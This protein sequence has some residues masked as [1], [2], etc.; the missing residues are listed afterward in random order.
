[1]ERKRQ[2]F[3]LIELL[4]VIAI[5]AVLI[6]LLLPAVQKVRSSAASTQS[7]NNL[8]Q[9]GVAV[10]N[11]HD[12]YK[13]TPP[14]FGTYGG[15]NSPMGSLFYHLLPFLEQ[16]NLYQMG[17][18][19]ARSQPLKVLQ[20]PLDATYGTGLFTL[21]AAMP[22]WYAP[23]PATDN[24]IPPWAGPST[25]WG[26]SSYGAN[27][28]FFGDN[29]ITLLAVTDGTSHT[30]M[31]AEKYAVPTRPVGN[32][33]SGATLWG[34]GVLP[35]PGT[36]YSVGLPPNSLYADSYWARVGFV[37]HAGVG[38][39][40][41]GDPNQPWACRCHKAPE[42]APPINNAHPLKAQ[43]FG[44]TINL[45][46]ADGSVVTVNSSIID[47]NYYYCETPAAGDISGD[48]QTP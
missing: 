13:V 34:Y 42:F 37:N 36:D 15:P 22:A 29:G 25:T 47:A 40:T 8:K 19:A 38:P 26:L 48:P 32:P 1:M 20:H 14:M 23:P 41:G 35:P 11:A 9:L 7:K 6:G 39:W 46:I 33:T 2:G 30:I 3:T 16:N 27:W 5:I 18:D 21:S 10:H 24:P 43:A 28:Q 31:F 12:N 45:C 44:Q 4:V 17:P